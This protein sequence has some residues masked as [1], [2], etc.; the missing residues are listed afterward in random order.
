VI[1]DGTAH[2]DLDQI[3]QVLGD[4]DVPSGNIYDIADIVA[5]PTIGRAR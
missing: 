2:H 4:A 1:S 3:L 5:D